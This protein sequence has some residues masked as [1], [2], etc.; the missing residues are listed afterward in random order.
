[1]P[2]KVL[3]Y[4]EFL[5][6]IGFDDSSHRELAGYLNSIPYEYLLDN[7]ENRMYDGTA[8]RREF[9]DFANGNTERFGDRIGGA[10]VDISTAPDGSACTMLEFLVGFA[11]RLC[12]DMFNDIKISEV[13][14][15][16]LEGLD[17]WKFVDEE[18]CVE[19]EDRIEDAL[20]IFLDRD[21][22]YDGSDGNIFV[23][24]DCEDDLRDVELWI[25]ASWWYNYWYC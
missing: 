25:Q 19:V 16:M 5:Y 7:D 8:M 12:R 1:M 20:D 23:V 14:E 13:V 11:Y 2:K 4:F 17:I 22:S 18:W 15:R 9:E 24:P 6:R 10:S 3:N 21:Y